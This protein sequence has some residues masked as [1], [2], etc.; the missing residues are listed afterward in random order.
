MDL[1]D[2]IAIEAMKVMLKSQMERRLTS[3]EDHKI[4]ISFVEKQMPISAYKIAD[5][6]IEE[7]K[8]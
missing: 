8:A 2:E 3:I 5:S 4:M 7:S 6:M 1:R